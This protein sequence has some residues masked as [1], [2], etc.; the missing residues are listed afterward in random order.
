MYHARAVRG[1][2]FVTADTDDR[3]AAET[4][5]VFGSDD[6]GWV[7]TAAAPPPNGREWAAQRRRWRR[8]RQ[9]ARR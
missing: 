1:P 3:A 2:S 5:A 4:P 8:R 9:I 7:D 6:R